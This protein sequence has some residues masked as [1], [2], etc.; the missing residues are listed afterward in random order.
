MSVLPHGELPQPGDSGLL[1]RVCSYERPRMGVA[2]SRG[3]FCCVWFCCVLH[4]FV[5]F[6]M[7][8]Y[9]PSSTSHTVSFYDSL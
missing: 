9:C 3:N 5:P 6:S 4:W 8:L 7:Y 1:L 2:V